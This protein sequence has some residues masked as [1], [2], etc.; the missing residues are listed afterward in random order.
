[1]IDHPGVVE[2]VKPPS[3]SVELRSMKQT[4]MNKMMSQMKYK[5]YDVYK[6]LIYDDKFSI[7]YVEDAL[8]GYALGAILGDLKFV[9]SKYKIPELIV[10]KNKRNEELIKL[11]IEAPN[12]IKNFDLKI[13][14]INEVRRINCKETQQLILNDFHMLPTRGHAGISRMNNNIKRYYYW[15][16]MKNDVEKFGK[17]CKDCQKCK[18]SILGKQP[19]TITT[20]SSS[21]MQSV[22]LDLVGP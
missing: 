21:A 10:M 8:P 1:M 20:T 15:S 14:L 22:F 9:T 12:I 13:S 2:L 4:E 3:G 19:M 18:Y 6:G 7:I 11:L 16:G 17:T 5:N